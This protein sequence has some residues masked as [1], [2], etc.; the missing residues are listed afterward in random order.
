MIAEVKIEDVSS[1]KKKLSFEVLWADV[2]DELDSIYRTV[3]RKAKIKGF[4]PGK[5]PRNVLEMHY[6][7]QVEEDAISNLIAKHYAEVVEKNN[8]LA[9]GQPAI[10][11]KGITTGENFLFT[12]TVETRPVIDLKSYTELKLEKEKLGITK[13]DI[14]ERL[15]QIRQMYSTLKDIEEDRAL[16]NDDFAVIDFE[17]KL[18]GEARKELASED[19]TLQIGS[20][21]FVPG[22]EE[23]LVGLKKGESRDIT[24]TF[25]ED[26][27]AKDIAGKEVLFSVTLKNIR[28]KL[29]PE[30][31]EEFVKNF[32]KIESLEDLKKDVKK[33]LEE[34]GEARI[35]ADL[36]NAMI[37]KLLENNEFEVPSSW[38]EEQV[39]T[40]MLNA[41]QQMMQNG[42][43][44]DKA[45]EIS[46][47]LRDGF[48]DQAT[49]IVKASFMFHEIAKKESIEV[50]EK[51][52]E[53]KLNALA[54]R[55]GQDYES[56]K[57]VYEANNAED[58]LKDELLEQKAVDFVE[59]R[60]SITL[61]KKGRKKKKEKGEK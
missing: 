23:Q 31:D 38:V 34:E 36:R 51:D 2:K 25:P 58:R 43:P 60:A 9:V 53:D 5:V 42:M 37:D 14:E 8:I 56:V 54:L 17:G 46:Y 45:S 19:Y 35:K 32:E 55:Y 39:Y 50:T 20:Q 29:L 12:A 7:E 4:R 61:V 28:E 59:E 22:F 16:A 48:N 41:R 44:D 30:L 1:V 33:S 24:V 52:V 15:N 27:G 3:G 57:R 10:D 49:R 26:Y 21:S 6:K 11:Q 13:A 18:D 47:N 40:M